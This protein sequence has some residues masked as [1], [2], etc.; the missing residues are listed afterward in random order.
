MAIN[1]NL[2]VYENYIVYVSG[3]STDHPQQDLVGAGFGATPI[4]MWGDQE[5]SPNGRIFCIA[6][7]NRCKQKDKTLSAK[8]YLT[9]ASRW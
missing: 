7:A 1:V 4:E 9:M 6:L 8:I 2:N 3:S 5:T